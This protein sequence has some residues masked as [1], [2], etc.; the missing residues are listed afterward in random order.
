M[1]RTLL[2]VG[3]AIILIASW[4]YP[5]W[6]SFLY[7]TLLTVAAFCA[8]AKWLSEYKPKT[9]GEGLLALFPIALIALF[10]YVLWRDA[11]TE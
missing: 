2:A 1:K 6:F 11:V 8:S 7:G 5:P 9:F 4:V 3:I 10:A